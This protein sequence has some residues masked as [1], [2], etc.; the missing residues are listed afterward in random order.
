MSVA[1]ITAADGVYHPT[2]AALIIGRQRRRSI[3][4]DR[5]LPL[6]TERAA[7][8]ERS[9]QQRQHLD[10]TDTDGSTVVTDGD[11]HTEMT[12]DGE[13]SGDTTVLRYRRRGRS[14]IYAEK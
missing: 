6:E 8:R 12:T 13:C 1:L 2:S 10:T 3:Y 5:Y 9:I 11:E 14:Y 4:P 7:R